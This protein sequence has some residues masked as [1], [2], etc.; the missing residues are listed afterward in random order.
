MGEEALAE[1]NI[2]SDATVEGGG[3]ESEPELRR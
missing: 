2:A 3:I 1:S